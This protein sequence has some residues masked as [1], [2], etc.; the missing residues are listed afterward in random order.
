MHHN[1]HIIVLLLSYFYR[2]ASDILRFEICF[3]KHCIPCKSLSKELPKIPFTYRLSPWFFVAFSCQDWLMSPKGSGLVLCQSFP[4]LKHRRQRSLWILDQLCTFTKQHPLGTSVGKS[5]FLCTFCN[6]TLH[7]W[8]I[9]SKSRS[10]SP[11]LACCLSETPDEAHL[12][13]L[14]TLQQGQSL[15]QMLPYQLTEGLVW[16]MTVYSKEES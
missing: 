5:A 16:R 4:L 15:G 7:F 12:A 10:T 9:C 14:F 11:Y 8:D 13:L 1:T 6:L 2:T 3:F